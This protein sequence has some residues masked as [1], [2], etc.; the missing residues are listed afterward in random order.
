MGY[1]T[2]LKPRTP[3]S[4]ANGEPEIK[5]ICVA[6]TAA[7]CLS[8]IGLSYTSPIYVYRTEKQVYA[9]KAWNVPDSD[10][11]D[12]HFILR[13]VNF[14][15]VCVLSRQQSK[16]MYMRGM[17]ET[18]GYGGNT[19]EYNDQLKEHKKIV[20]SISRYK[21]ELSN[22][23]FSDNRFVFDDVYVGKWTREEIRVEDDYFSFDERCKA[24]Q[25]RRKRQISAK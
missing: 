20:S 25:R 18:R 14:E 8:A 19:K 3:F 10:L 23:K 2:R 16:R 15:L 9:T 11:T 5:R 17:F 6:P 24:N 22:K 12:E 4:M 1:N 21:K 13:P 7:H